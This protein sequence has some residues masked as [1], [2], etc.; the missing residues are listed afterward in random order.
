MPVVN[1]I[2]GGLTDWLEDKSTEYHKFKAKVLRVLKVSEYMCIS[3]V[4]LYCGRS[5]F[6]SL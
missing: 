5:K 2:V 6:A 1:E 4:I 3:L